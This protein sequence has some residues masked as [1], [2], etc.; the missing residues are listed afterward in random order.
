[1]LQLSDNYERKAYRAEKLEESL[2]AKSNES[3]SLIP[4]IFESFIKLPKT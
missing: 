1:M 4:K 2:R 3:V